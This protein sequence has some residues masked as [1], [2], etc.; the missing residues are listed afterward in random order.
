[1]KIVFYILLISLICFGLFLG[2]K[3]LRWIFTKKIRKTVASF[4]IVV[5]SSSYFIYQLLFVKM[6]FIQSK[7][8]PNLYLVKNEIKDRDSLNDIIKK[9]IRKEIES[10]SEISKKIYSENSYE[11]PY[12]TFA[13]YTYHKNSKLNIFQDYGT[14]FFIDNEEDLGGIVVED[15]GMYSTYK[16]ATFNIVAHQKDTLQHYGVVQYFNDG[17]VV[18]TD[19]LLKSK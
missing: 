15:L 19:T 13:F 17:N 5:I 8:Y 12:A 4:L 9:M 7:V 1:M 16:L 3:I 18:K 10:N 14:A 11:A 6:E 2:Y